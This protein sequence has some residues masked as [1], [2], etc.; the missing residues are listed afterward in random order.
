MTVLAERVASCRISYSSTQLTRG[1]IG[2]P[3]QYRSAPVGCKPHSGLHQATQQPH[4]EG[5][6]RTGASGNKDKPAC[7]SCIGWCT[8]C[9][10]WASC[11]SCI[12]HTEQLKRQRLSLPACPVLCMSLGGQHTVIVCLVTMKLRFQ[13][14]GQ[15]V[16]GQL[17]HCAAVGALEGTAWPVVA[18]QNTLQTTLLSLRCCWQ[19]F[20]E[21]ESCPLLWGIKAK[22]SVQSRIL[23]QV[24]GARRF[25]CAHLYSTSRH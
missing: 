15:S 13:G 21:F 2:M 19:S 1:N 7:C 9:N 17:A 8:H 10:C 6:A 14:H 18:Q 20:K 16:A 4:T 22:N 5:S 25:L 12:H 23:A 24:D 11:M 3:S